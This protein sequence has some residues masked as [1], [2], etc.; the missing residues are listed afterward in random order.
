MHLCTKPGL[1]LRFLV[2]EWV[3]EPSDLV[4]FKFP[5]Q[6]ECKPR[7][8]WNTPLLSS[9]FQSFFT[10]FHQTAN[11]S[12]FKQRRC[13]CTRV[14]E[15]YLF[16]LCTLTQGGC[17]NSV[18][19]LAFMGPWCCYP[20][21]FLG[22]LTVS[23]PFNKISNILMVDRNTTSVR[24]KNLYIL[25]TKRWI[26]LYIYFI[27]LKIDCGSQLKHQRPDLHWEADMSSFPGI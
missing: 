25:R 14:R 8:K 23:G 16:I 21:Y 6:E 18:V 9:F 15:W 27:L 2:S 3:W 20:V 7:L 26:E 12:V 5:R 11:E 24:K 19:L 17:S 10:C 22:F 13:V 4:V 1:N